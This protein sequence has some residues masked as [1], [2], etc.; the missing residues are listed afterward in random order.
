[1]N[2]RTATIRLAT[3]ETDV[4]V[5]LTLDGIGRADV[6]TGI[7][8]YDHLLTALARHARF[9]LVLRCRG[10]LDVDD[11]HTVEDCALVLGQALDQALGD[12]RG[13]R[14]FASAFAPLDEALARAVI[15]LSGRPW[16]EIRLEIRSDRIGAMSGE[17]VAHAVRS[18]AT[19]GRLCVHLD[20]ERGEND[21]HNAEAAF[22]A[23]ALALRE[24]VAA[25]GFADVP[26]TKGT[27]GVPA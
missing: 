5:E 20:L 11:H 9:D 14:R 6:S 18:F 25:S 16:A 23:L 3:A 2:T 4:T 19:A 22:K 8:F 21:H 13:V 24:A 27:L 7:G 10:D 12:R 15:D 1:M 26:S 17:N